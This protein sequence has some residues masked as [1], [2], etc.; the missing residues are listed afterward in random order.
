M[1]TGRQ[2]YWDSVGADWQRRRPQRLWREFSDRQQIGLLQRW[3]GGLLTRWATGWIGAE[4][5]PELLKTDL[6]DE[7]ASQ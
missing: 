6:F 2:D 3:T 1:T 4:R 7:V 5:R